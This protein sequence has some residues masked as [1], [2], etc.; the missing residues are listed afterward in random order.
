MDSDNDVCFDV[1]EAGFNDPNN[2]GILGNNPVTVNAKGTVT[3]GVGYTAPNNNYIIAA[4]I[5]ITSQPLANPTCELENTTITVAD[6]GGNT[7]QWQLSIDGITW[8][9]ILNNATYQNATAKT[10]TLIKVTNAMNGYKYR[11]K[12]DKIGNSCG[13]ISSETTLTIYTLPAVN[14]V[15]IVQCDDDTDGFSNFNLTVKNNEISTNYTS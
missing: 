12:L 11:V 6:N 9:N 4:P 10:L 5:E 2:D 15:T 1:I 14:T 3:S 13:L 8:N 7:Y